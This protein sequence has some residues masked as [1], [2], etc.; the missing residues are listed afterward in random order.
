[1]KQNPSLHADELMVSI[2]DYYFLIS[3]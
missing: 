1:M 3:I 2:Q